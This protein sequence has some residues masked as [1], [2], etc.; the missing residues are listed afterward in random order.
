MARERAKHSN[1]ETSLMTDLNLGWHLAMDSNSLMAIVT[2]FLLKMVTM[3]P[4]GLRTAI[5]KCSV[6][7]KGLPIRKD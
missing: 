2:D 5:V 1:W 6:I 4:K 7:M 3:T